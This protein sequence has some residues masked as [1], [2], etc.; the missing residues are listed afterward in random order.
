MTSI[1][2]SDAASSTHRS[3][4]ALAVAM[5][6]SAALTLLLTGCKSPE[7][8]AQPAAAQE[9]V[10]P[11]VVT[12]LSDSPASARVVTATGTLGGKEEVQLAFKIG[13]IVEQVHVDAGQRVRAGQVLATLRPT[14]IAAQVRTASEGRA[15][16]QRDLDRARQLYGDS[17]ATL[18]QLQDATTALTI[19]QQQERIAR[20]NADF[21][22]V[23]AASDGVVLQ[24]LAEPGQVIEPGR[25]VLAVR[26]AARGMVVRAGVADRLAVQ[27]TEG[28]T[29]TV[30]F[31]AMAGQAFR[32]RV[33]R[34]AAAAT[35]G[36]GSYQLEIT[37]GRDA[38]AL[39]S[40][41]VGT[42][43][44]WL[45]STARASASPG[46]TVP[47]DALVDA[48]ADSGA[49]FVLADDARTVRRVPVRLGDIATTLAEGTVPVR[50]GLTGAERV[51]TAGTSRLVN[52]SRVRVVTA[53]GSAAP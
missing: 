33:T 8:D 14:E 45:R 4:R 11:V 42:V 16:A 9:A 27:V 18:Q 24:R 32:G 35:Q 46:I 2:P 7:A 53:T 52:G 28:D 15:K 23:R 43:T 50:D 19:A 34:R 25:P 6:A 47:T 30:V 39:P 20:F 1:N 44:V 48:D 41:L 31:D 29:A 10:L 3:Q 37:L 26:S 38:A 36:T 17:V 49:V 13:G 12:N 51:V 5:L 21:A 40:G 22:A